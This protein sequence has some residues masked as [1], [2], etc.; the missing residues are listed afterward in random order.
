MPLISRLEKNLEEL[1]EA[2][3]L[4]FKSK[5]IINSGAYNKVYKVEFDHIEVE[6]SKEIT[7]SKEEKINLYTSVKI[8]A[9]GTFAVREQKEKKFFGD[10]LK[11]LQEN[12]ELFA[13]HQINFPFIHQPYALAKGREI[14]AL[15]KGDLY[16]H[17]EKPLTSTEM[18]DILGQI[19]LAV[20]Y[21]HFYNLAHCDLKIENFLMFGSRVKLADFDGIEKVNAEGFA[22]P[23]Q[24]TLIYCKRPAPELKAWLCSDENYPVNLKAAD[25]FAIGRIIGDLLKTSDFKENRGEFIHLKRRLLLAQEGRPTIQEIKE[26]VVFGAT[27]ELRT[28]FFKRLLDKALQEDRQSELYIDGFLVSPRKKDEF[29][30]FPTA[31][32]NIHYYG[33]KVINKCKF[34][35]GV[36]HLLKQE[37]ST[38][39][40]ERMQPLV[41]FFV[42]YQELSM[43]LKEI[44]RALENQAL[45]DFHSKLYAIQQNLKLLSEEI[46]LHIIEIELQY[47]PKILIDLKKNLLEILQ[48]AV[49]EF[50]IKNKLLV[51]KSFW[52]NLFTFHGNKGRERVLKVKAFVEKIKNQDD[53]SLPHTIKKLFNKIL[54]IRKGEGGWHDLSFKTILMNKYRFIHPLFNEINIEQLKD[55]FE[56]LEFQTFRH[57]IIN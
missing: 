24:E 22:M 20:D 23:N 35:L 46:R 11:K 55:I 38:S 34:L 48:G 9:G 56:G 43:V 50:L 18:Q 5:K 44:K 45:K 32:K 30:F 52:G 31:I 1:I 21:L 28:Q 47:N 7:E 41:S 37:P 25:C 6:E 29:Y 39:T 16:E 54:Q 49:N 33:L 12:Y 2:S 27:Q 36:F 4:I 26:S 51:E 8:S 15:A 42:M 14:S 17:L 57:K 53:E 40:Y 10:Q 13:F 19:V 3:R